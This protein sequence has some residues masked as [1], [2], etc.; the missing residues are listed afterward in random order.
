VS[1]T[2]PDSQFTY[3]IVFQIEMFVMLN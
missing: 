2:N 1:V 3:Y